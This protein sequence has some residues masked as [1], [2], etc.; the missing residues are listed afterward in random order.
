MKQRLLLPLLAITAMLA[1]PAAVS[2]AITEIGPLG[3]S[4]AGCPG[5]SAAD[6]KIVVARQTGFQAKVGTTTAFTTAKATGNVVAWSISLVSV[7]AAK[8]KTVSTTYG[9]APKAAVVI[10][11]PLGKS[12][13]RVVGKGPLVDL[14]DYLGTTPTF[15]LPTALPI[16]AGQVVG[17]TV[18]TWAPILQLGVGGDTSW[19]SSKPLKESVE[20]NYGT[21]R[22]LVGDTTDGFFAALYQRARLVYSA[23]VVPNPAK[24]KTTTTS[25][26]AKTTPS[27]TTK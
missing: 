2:A 27:K 3:T 18:P 23:T 20:G 9:G 21:Q 5:F 26:T 8:V 4:V 17:I 16:K 13:F 6:C 19:R 14:T 22:A 12:N 25:T 10:L 15:A 24:T 7:P 11:Q 1:V